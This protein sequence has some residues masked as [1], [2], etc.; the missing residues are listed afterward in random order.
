MLAALERVFPSGGGTGGGTE[1]MRLYAG[2][3]DHDAVARLAATAPVTSLGLRVAPLLVDRVCTDRVISAGGVETSAEPWCGEIVVMPTVSATGSG[4]KLE[5]GGHSDAIGV[6]D[7]ATGEA[8]REQE[9][10][11]TAKGAAGQACSSEDSR[12]RARPADG[13]PSV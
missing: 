10:E 6:D 9:E 11:P 7:E 13:R 2:E 1:G 3:N 8:R 4:G 12:R 5:N